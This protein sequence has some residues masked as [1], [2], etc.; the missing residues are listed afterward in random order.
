MSATIVHSQ[1]PAGPVR[2]F[3]RR[4]VLSVFFLLVFALTWPLLIADALGSQGVLSFRLPFGALLLTGYMP[5]CAAL[6]ATALAD[7]KAGVGVLLRK[8]LIWRVGVPWYGVALFGFAVICLAVVLLHGLVDGL[9]VR[10]LL[11]ADVADVPGVELALNIAVL[12]GVSL[13][14]NTE[15]V[16]W[17]GFALPHLQA[18]WN[19][20]TASVLLGLVWALF[21]LPLFYTLTGSSQADRS[22]AAFAL[23]TVA[24]SVIFTWLY[25]NTRGSVLLASL[26]HA[27]INTWSRVFPIDHGGARVDWLMAGMLCLVAV[28]LILAFGAQ[29]LTRR[30]QRIE[31]AS[32]ARAP[33]IMPAT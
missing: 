11:A 3:V 12:F 9:P 30:G 17:R 22:M 25:N 18:R 15:E 4:H 24:L 23:Q 29:H 5:A 32:A 7:G 19:A 13:L 31:A 6:V 8:L 21:H 28:I 33:S 2:A 14:I 26:L 20:L 27:S 16:A 10:S 1:L